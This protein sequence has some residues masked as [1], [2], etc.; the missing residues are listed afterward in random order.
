MAVETFAGLP[1]EHPVFERYS[2]IRPE[3]LPRFQEIVNSVVARGTTRSLSASARTRLL[4]AGLAYIEPRH[5]LGLV[6][7]AFGARVMRARQARTHLPSH[8]AQDV[9]FYDPDRYMRAA[10]VGDNILFGRISYG[11]PNA[12]ER[13][14]EIARAIVAELD[15]DKYIFRLGLEFDVGKAGWQLQPAQRAR[16]AICRALVA[17]PAILVL[18]NAFTTLTKTELATLVRT[19]ARQ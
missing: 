16:V 18:E 19:F 2:A 5:R 8:Y 4:G 13:V 10:P 7:K 12:P 17:N 1:P 9:E 11:I 14:Y 3:D 6:D 15:L